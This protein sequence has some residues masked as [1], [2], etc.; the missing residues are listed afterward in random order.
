[1]SR[2]EW[3]KLFCEERKRKGNTSQDGLVVRNAF[4]ADYDRIVGSSSVRR[5]Q[6]K[7]Q[8]FPLQKNDFVRTRLTHSIEVSA[9]ARSL[10]KAVGINLEKKGFF[11][12]E[13]TEKLAALLQTAGLIHDLGN[14]PFGHYGEQVIRQWV[15]EKGK[16]LQE[17]LDDEQEYFDFTRFDGN[18]QNLRIVTKL[19]TMSDHNGANFTYATLATIIKYPYSSISKKNHGEKYGYFKS[20]QDIVERIREA[21]GLEEGIRHPATYL[22]EAADDIIY[23]CDDIEDGVKKGYINWDNAFSSL[24]EEFKGDDVYRTILQNIADKYIDKNMDEKEQLLGR[25]RVFR[26]YI[27]SFLFEK[28]VEAFL[29][30]YDLIMQGLYE[31]ELMKK[32]QTFIRA[33]KKITSVNCFACKEV[34]SLEVAGDRVIKELLNILYNAL[35]NMPAEE[36]GK[37]RSYEEKIYQM[38]SANYKYIA[39]FDYENENRGRKK[40]FGELSSYDKLHL[41]VDFVS[42]MTDSFA[43]NLYKELTGI[44]LPE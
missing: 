37:P 16:E 15:I 7:A 8:V 33:L 31:G 5:L 29:D 17:S 25:V 35:N 27:Q 1:M 30:E 19:Q 14:P 32:Q 39:T 12:R 11:G 20:E 13:E 28:A 40:S 44:S 43:V 22:L 41:I 24:K 42:G 6:D 36:S 4:E 2:L 26:N 21:T 34:L 23:I 38:I 3:S 18:V 9:L 10:G